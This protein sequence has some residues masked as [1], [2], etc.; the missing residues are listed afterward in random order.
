MK[1]VRPKEEHYHGDCIGS[2]IVYRD[3]EY[4]VQGPGH[5][6]TQAA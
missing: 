1:L 5:P 4:Q 3:G 2:L 6:V